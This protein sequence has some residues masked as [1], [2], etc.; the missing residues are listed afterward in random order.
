[1]FLQSLSL[2][3][4]KNYEKAEI[5]FC[6]HFNC[7]VGINGSGKTNILDAIY[8]L[9]ST[10]SAFHALDSQSINHD[11]QYFVIN[12]EIS[13][14][15]KIHNVHCSL[16]KNSRKTFKVDD[17]EYDKLSEHIGKFPVVLIAPNDDELIR[18]SNEV[19]RKFFDSI[20][21]QYDSE[22][23]KT[24]IR[25]NHIL[26]QRNALLKSMA[27]SGKIDTLMLETYNEPLIRDSRFIASKRSRFV[28]EF[29]PHFQRNYDRIAEGRE[30]VDIAYESKALMKDFELKYKEGLQKDM[31]TQRTNLGIHRDEYLFNIG[32]FP[33]KK[34]GSQGQQKSLLVSLKLAQF[35]FIKSHLKITPVLLLD[36]IF[37]KLDDGR[38]AQLM[39][40]IGSE[41]FG[42][43][44]LT[45]ARE[46]RTRNL[47][48]GKFDP[49]KIFRV[50]SNKIQEVE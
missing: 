17:S 20:I 31:L 5:S 39:S 45:D 36:D 37:D 24:L 40:I 12:G 8:Y 25:Y 1:M 33:I 44:F 11:D 29:V 34:Y 48:L 3:Y 23:L 46:E 16:K 4:F 18:E 28:E 7:L 43:V 10:K 21:S 30:P 9:S 14:A 35:E 27:D 22:Y 15:D 2:Q 49:M 47:L 26:K 6:N 38:I 42:Q 41:D 32:G 19:R 13:I 50:E